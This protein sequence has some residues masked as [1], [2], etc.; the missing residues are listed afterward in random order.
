MHSIQTYS[1]WSTDPGSIHRRQLQN[2]TDS[3]SSLSLSSNDGELIDHAVPTSDLAPI[4]SPAAP[5]AEPPVPPAKDIRT[6]ELAT[7]ILNASGINTRG[8]P[9]LYPPSGSV[10]TIAIPPIAPG[11]RVLPMEKDSQVHPLPTPAA[12]YE[13]GYLW[14]T[15]V[16]DTPEEG[17]IPLYSVRTME[18]EREAGAFTVHTQPIVAHAMDAPDGE[19]HPVFVASMGGH[20]QYFNLPDC[21]FERPLALDGSVTGAG[22]SFAGRGVAGATTANRD[23]NPSLGSL[24]SGWNKGG[25]GMG[26]IPRTTSLYFVGGGKGQK[27]GVTQLNVQTLM[28]SPIRTPCRRTSGMFRASCTRKTRS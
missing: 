18:C 26:Y 21:E 2:T 22:G 5:A 4:A 9:T 13:R 6:P 17:F 24:L 1:T 28:L 16:S 3:M 7:A 19:H 8:S 27:H 23:A 15:P 11:P 10:L 12:I 25:F 20:V 14:A